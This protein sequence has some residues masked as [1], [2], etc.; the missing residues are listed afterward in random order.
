MSA[1]SGPHSELAVRIGGYGD[2]RAF[3]GGIASV[4]RVPGFFGC[5]GGS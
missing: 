2:V 4:L 1:M 5:S 3:S